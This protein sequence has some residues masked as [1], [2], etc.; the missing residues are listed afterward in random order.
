MVTGGLVDKR[1]SCLTLFVHIEEVGANEL[2]ETEGLSCLGRFGR[3]R[4]LTSHARL[5]SKVLSG[6]EGRPR[7]C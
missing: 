6:L 1:S 2:V 5:T 7:F 4:L 3:S